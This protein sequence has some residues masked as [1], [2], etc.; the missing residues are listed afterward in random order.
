MPRWMNVKALCCAAVAGLALSTA[1]A[2]AAEPLKVTPA[3]RTTESASQVTTEQVRW[4]RGWNR[5]GFGVNIS[6]RWGVGVTVGPRY[7]PRR[8]YSP[9]YYS[10]PRYYRNYGYSYPYY[11]NYYNSPYG[12]G[13]G[14][15][16]DW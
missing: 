12:Y 10:Y 5:G 7:Y 4:R 9:R 2:P 1:T 15:Y 8:Y 3:V 14:Y 11:G 6:P 13:Y 16:Y